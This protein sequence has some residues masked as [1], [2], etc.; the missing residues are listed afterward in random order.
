MPHDQDQPFVSDARL[1]R[2]FKREDSQAAFAALA[3]RH[4]KMVYSVCLRDVRD[5]AGAEDAAQ[6]VF[7]VL[8]RKAPALRDDGSLTG[9]LYQ[10]ARLVSKN[11]L[12]REARVRRIEQRA[13]QQ[14]A[15]ETQTE[16]DGLWE[17]IDPSLHAALDALGGVEREAVLL[18]F[19]DGLSLTETGTALG[20]SED[21]A[22]MR[23]TRALEKLRRF[24]VKEGVTVSVAVL[25]GLLADKSAQ[26][27]PVSAVPRAIQTTTGS[28]TAS[29]HVHQLAQGATR[30]IG[31]TKAAVLST[32][33]GVGLG[34]GIWGTRHIKPH[35]TFP[36]PV[37]LR[38]T[39]P[40]TVGTPDATVQATA[41]SG[42][43]ATAASGRQATLPSGVQVE[44]LGVSGQAGPWWKPDGTP[45]PNAPWD[46]AEFTLS[47]TFKDEP[48]LLRQFALRL[49]H[50]EGQALKESTAV[51][52][53]PPKTGGETTLHPK[54]A[55]TA[56]QEVVRVFPTTQAT[57]TLRYGL[58]AG[59]WRTAASVGPRLG[60][61]RD[62]AGGSVQFAW[63]TP[64]PIYRDFKTG[65]QTPAL[66]VTDALGPCARRVVA[67]L[68]DG[69]T[70]GLDDMYSDFPTPK[71]TRL[72]APLRLQWAEVKTRVKEFRLE[73]RAYEWVEF[74]DVHLQPRP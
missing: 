14:M 35:H 18:R 12:R 34:G 55:G 39:S 9:W 43:Q 17:Q 67:V 1:L 50:T 37:V 54:E 71:T 10:T 47:S 57:C 5:A 26:A 11:A 29:P 61:A 68:R 52:D 31:M 64:R 20:L 59:P 33:I 13:A 28:A 32:V 7:L 38:P 16:Q 70:V 62:G 73:T 41:A 58:A 6:A 46:S 66:V 44:M 15:Q 8:A 25:A 60:A 45:L 30:M 27:A 74:K 69:S 40:A 22:R 19:F 51:F 24:L 63:D 49:T 72:H 2:R 23:V 42:R 36:P 53:G 48:G 56:L 65:K 21:A 3:A 4:Y